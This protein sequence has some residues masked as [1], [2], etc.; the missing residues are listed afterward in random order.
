MKPQENTHSTHLVIFRSKRRCTMTRVTTNLGGTT[1]DVVVGKVGQGLM[2]MTWTPVP[3]PD[4][5]CFEAI[6]AGIDA[7]PPGARMFLNGGEFY[8]HNL[9]TTNLEMIARFFEKY[10]EYVDRTFLSI[11]GG[12]LPGQLVS[13]G[14][15]ENLTRSV[16]LVNEKLR[17]TKR[18]DLFQCARVDPNVPV[19][20]SIAALAKLK[21]EGKLDHIG[22][23]ECSAET[24][25]R[26]HQVHPISV[27]EIEISPFSYESQT[28]DVIAT[29]K[30]L[31]VAVA[32]YSPLGRGFFTGQIKRPEDV[33][34]GDFRRHMPRFQE[35]SLKHN[36]AIVDAL[37]EIAK[38]KNITPAQLSIGW[39][40]SLGSHVIPLPGSSHAKRTL[41]NSA[42][43]DVVFTATELQE[44][45]QV[46]ENADVKGSR[47]PEHTKYLWA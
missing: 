46:I 32:G 29:A 45:N 39:V 40:S 21:S 20:V 11:K 26:G 38:K 12:N 8:C 14:S 15:P 44:I 9:S 18:L 31:G 33:P 13:D 42:G 19:E 30:E 28:R 7:L 1:S 43:G 2:M 5:Q 10:P 3:V 4:E 36:F 25:R 16:N 22:M 35:D 6:K 24:L 23:C 27:V 34:E 37:T 47:Y 17:G 41:E